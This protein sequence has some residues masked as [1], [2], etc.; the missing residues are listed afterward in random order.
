MAKQRGPV[1]FTGKLGS[2]TGFKVDGNYFIRASEDDG[3]QGSSKAVSKKRNNNTEFGNAVRIAKLIRYTT[4]NFGK[5]LFIQ[6]RSKVNRLNS[7]LLDIKNLDTVSPKGQFKVLPQYLHHVKGFEFNKNAQ[8]KNI[9]QCKWELTVDRESQ[10]V[11][12]LIH[13]FL[14]KEGLKVPKGCTHFKLLAT[15][16][17]VNIEDKTQK[18]SLESTNEWPVKMGEMIAREIVLN[19]PDVEKGHVIITFGVCFIKKS[20]LKREF[21]RNRNG[22]RII[23]VVEI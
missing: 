16:G 19:I 9:V 3:G 8:V 20:G 7:I 11:R 17:V 22:L 5:N 13:P 15:A 10:Q 18:A 6:E 4:A 2:L 21:M 1:P 14:P 12:I 23:D